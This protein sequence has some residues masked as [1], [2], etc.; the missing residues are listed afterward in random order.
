MKEVNLDKNQFLYNG[1]SVSSLDMGDGKHIRFTAKDVNYD[2][3]VV[4]PDGST[5][6]FPVPDD[7]TYHAYEIKGTKGQTYTFSISS[8]TTDSVNL[9]VPQMIVKID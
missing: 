9:T 2:L 3:S 7:G 1:S 8:S 6:D 4:R 5:G